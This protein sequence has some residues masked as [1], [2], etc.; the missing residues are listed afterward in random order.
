MNVLVLRQVS[1]DKLL[2]NWLNMI[3]QRLTGP[4]LSW[5]TLHVKE[6]THTLLETELGWIRQQLKTTTTTYTHAFF[7]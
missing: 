2:A 4:H 7:Q 5:V 3:V 6:I 1:E